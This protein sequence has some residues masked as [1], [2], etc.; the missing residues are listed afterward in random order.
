MHMAY[1]LSFRLVFSIERVYVC[2][3]DVEVW[4]PEFQLTLKLVNYFLLGLQKLTQIVQFIRH[5]KQQFIH[6]L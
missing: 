6:L 3:L 2:G 5:C 1:C 4:Q